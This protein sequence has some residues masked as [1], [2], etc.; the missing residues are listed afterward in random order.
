MIKNF[1]V[2]LNK[3]DNHLSDQSDRRKELV[4]MK[5][6]GPLRLHFILLVQNICAVGIDIMTGVLSAQAHTVFKKIS[7][8]SI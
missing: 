1:L 5:K 8:R 2:A 6:T 7:W 3:A 4:Y